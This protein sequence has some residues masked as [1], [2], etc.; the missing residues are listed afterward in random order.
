MAKY[1]RVTGGDQ[2]SS[3]SKHVSAITLASYDYRYLFSSIPRYLDF[4]DEVIVGVDSQGLTWSGGRVD[5]PRSFFEELRRLDET[6]SKIR[7][8]SRPFYST[9]HTPMEND[10]AERNALSLET[11]HDSWIVSIDA[12]ELLLNPGDFFRFLARVENEVDVYASW[13]T[14]FKDLGDA[15]LVI[16]A[17]S[18]GLLERFPIAT[19]RRGGFVASRR[20]ET[21][22]ILSPGV[23]LHY[24]WGRG[25][26]ELQEKL[27]N[28]T[29]TRDFDVDTYF[30]FWQG[31][32]AANYSAVRQ[33]HPIWPELWSRLVKVSKGDLENW[34]L[35][36]LGYRPKRSL[37]RV[38]RRLWRRIRRRVGASDGNPMSWT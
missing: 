18:D 7:V 1:S 2:R 15:L 24:S 33:F 20:T 14:S 16:A 3:M 30:R 9:S 35:W 11:R 21:N 10:I 28:W 36:D 4:V 17:Q 38:G 31:V 34:D 19:L 26:R 8:V 22:S 37:V 23:A 29:H 13:I 32:T 25:E 5:I 12:D 27:L 6:G